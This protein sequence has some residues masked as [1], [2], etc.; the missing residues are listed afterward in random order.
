VVVFGASSAGIIALRMAIRHPTL[1]R[2]VLAFEPGF[3]H[4]VADGPALHGAIVAPMRE[5][6]DGHPADWEGAYAAFMGAAAPESGGL[7][8]PLLQQWHARREV[9]NAE[10]LVR[11]DVPVLTAE[12]ADREGIS[13]AAVEIRLSVGARSSPIFRDIAASLADVRGAVPDEIEGIGH[14]CYLEPDIV[15][16]YIGEHVR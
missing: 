5:H 10:P 4:E 7:L 1:V 15:A 9:M 16:A 6:L 14:A 12:R 8:T 3:F 2:R 13:A 11:D